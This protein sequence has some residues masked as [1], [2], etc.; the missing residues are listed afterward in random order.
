MCMSWLLLILIVSMHGLTM[1]FTRV[2]FNRNVTLLFMYFY[3]AFLSRIKEGQ[4]DG[5]LNILDVDFTT[6]NSLKKFLKY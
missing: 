4:T 3:N 5:L 1:K 6:Q 2:V